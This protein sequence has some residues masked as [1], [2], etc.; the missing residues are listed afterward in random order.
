MRPIKEKDYKSF[1]IYG[2]NYTATFYS[3]DGALGVYKNI[4]HGRLVGRKINDEIAILDE[5]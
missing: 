3:F 1:M 2:R 5:K 4:D